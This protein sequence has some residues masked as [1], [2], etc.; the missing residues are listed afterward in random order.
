MVPLVALGPHTFIILHD[1]LEAEVVWVYLL[2]KLHLV[3]AHG[4]GAAVLPIMNGLPRDALRSGLSVTVWVFN[5]LP[6][7][8]LAAYLLHEALVRVVALLGMYWL[9][10][11]Y[12]PARSVQRC[13]RRAARTGGGRGAAVGRAARLQHLWTERAGPAVAAARRAGPA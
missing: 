9:L 11:R 8:P 4:P 6:D 13:F 12:G 7:S 3:L 1:S 2:A 10:R 5:L